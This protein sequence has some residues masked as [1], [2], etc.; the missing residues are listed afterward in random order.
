[1]QDWRL[2]AASV[3]TPA[4]INTVTVPSEV[5]RNTS[6]V[7]SAPDPPRFDAAGALPLTVPVT[8]MSD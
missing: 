4:A 5:P 8:V 1:M 3:A 2:P 7:Y 6:K